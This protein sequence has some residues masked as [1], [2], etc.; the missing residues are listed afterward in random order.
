MLGFLRYRGCGEGGL[1]WETEED[2]EDEKPRRWIDDGEKG[3]GKNTLEPTG[4]AE[5]EGKKRT[6]DE[7]SKGQHFRREGGYL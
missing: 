5:G 7:V 4:A 6:G 2:E 1:G 3:T